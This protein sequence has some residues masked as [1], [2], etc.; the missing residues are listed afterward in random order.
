MCERHP[1]DIIAHL[2][3]APLADSF[4]NLYF[5]TLVNRTQFSTGAVGRC[6]GIDYSLRYDCFSALSITLMQ[7]TCIRTCTF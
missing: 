5:G 1:T 4:S 6:L 3:A 7:A 2:D